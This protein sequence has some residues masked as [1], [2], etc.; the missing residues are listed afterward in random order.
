[1]QSMLFAIAVMFFKP[2]SGGDD[3]ARLCTPPTNPFCHHPPFEPLPKRPNNKGVALFGAGSTQQKPLQMFQ[4]PEAL[5]LECAADS[6]GEDP[7]YL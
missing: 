5:S 7:V 1:M 3:P 6:R 2:D 4:Q